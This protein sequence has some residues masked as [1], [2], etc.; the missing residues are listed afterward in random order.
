MRKYGFKS[1]VH[2]PLIQE[3]TDYLP[4]IYKFQVGC[5][6]STIVSRH[7]LFTVKKTK[8][9]ALYSSTLEVFLGTTDEGRQGDHSSRIVEAPKPD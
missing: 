2:F 9:Y 7:I 5:Y 6:S 8:T 4:S 1:V 3:G